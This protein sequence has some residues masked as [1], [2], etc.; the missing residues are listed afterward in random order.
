MHNHIIETVMFKLSP[1]VQKEDF[2]S[3]AEAS[4]DYVKGCKGFIAR[5]LSS[6]KDGNWVEHIEWETM[7]DA[8]AAAAALGNAPDIGPFLTAIHPG[9]VTM[10]HTE[11]SISIG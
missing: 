1:H 8:S 2:L 4:S 9:T 6:D 7:A 5:R 10:H 11:V 3:F